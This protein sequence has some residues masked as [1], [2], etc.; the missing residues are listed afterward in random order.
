MY[1]SSNNGTLF[2]GFTN[3]G[4]TYLLNYFLHQKQEPILIIT[5]SVNQHPNIKAQTSGEIQPLEI[6]ENSMVVFDD[7]LLS[8]Q[9]NNIDMFFT[10]GRHKNTDI[11]YKSQSYFHLPKNTIR[12]I[13]DINVLFKHTIR[14]ITILFHDTAV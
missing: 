4:K 2:V 1:K 9:E 11:Y 10:Q 6:Y 5:K 7:M 3:C 8:K 14:D 13:S 12:N